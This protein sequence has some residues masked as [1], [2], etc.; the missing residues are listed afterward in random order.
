VSERIYQEVNLYQPIFRQQRHVFS[1]VAMLQSMAV[2]LVALVTIYAYGLWQVSKLDAESLELEGREKAYS[3]QLARLDPSTGIGQRRN[4]EREIQSL[5]SVLLA[6]QRLIEVLQEQPPGNASG[7]SSALKALGR[8][9][10][11]GLWLTEIRFN[12][13]TD[14]IELRG[15]TIDP[16]MVPAYLLRLG[17]EE[18]LTGQRFD[19]FEIVRREDDGKIVFSVSSE[20]V[21][22]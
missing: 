15:Q 9:Y 6:R 17:E 12:G 18:A 13:V 11:P 4:I 19:S 5:N 10:S 14:S 22:Q 1:A 16:A 2:V 8:R 21:D 3:A 7:F 20:A